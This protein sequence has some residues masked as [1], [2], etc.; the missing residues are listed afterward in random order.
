MKG[1]LVS[2]FFGILLVFGLSL[3]ISISQQISSKTDSSGALGTTTSSAPFN[4]NTIPKS[5]PKGGQSPEEGTSQ[6]PRKTRSYL[7]TSTISQTFTLNTLILNT[8]S[9]SSSLPI[10]STPSES[11]TSNVFSIRSPDQ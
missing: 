11:T 5:L 10:D 7:A 3:S 9:F 4:L 2:T 6:S 8:N 1:S